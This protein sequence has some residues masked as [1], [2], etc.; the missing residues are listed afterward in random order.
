MPRGVLEGYVQ[1]FGPEEALL[2]AEHERGRVGHREVGD[3][4]LPASRPMWSAAPKPAYGAYVKSD[5]TP[6]T[7][8]RGQPR[9]SDDKLDIRR[10]MTAVPGCYPSPGPARTGA[11]LVTGRIRSVAGMSGRPARW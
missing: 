7:Q 2:D 8:Y 5:M 3:G 4:D 9:L 11:G 6:R 1:P 10:A